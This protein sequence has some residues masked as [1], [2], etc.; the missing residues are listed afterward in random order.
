[1]IFIFTIPLYYCVYITNCFS[2]ISILYER[3]LN[4]CFLLFIIGRDEFKLELVLGKESPF[5]VKP[6]EGILEPYKPIMIA[7]TFKPGYVI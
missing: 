6:E 2:Y 7:V 5:S 1:M 3:T 4:N